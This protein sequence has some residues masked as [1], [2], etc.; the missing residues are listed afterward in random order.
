MR[1]HFIWSVA[2]IFAVSNFRRRRKN[3]GSFPDSRA[4]FFMSAACPSVLPDSRISGFS[5]YHF[6]T[7]T[8]L[9]LMTAKHFSWVGLGWVGTF[10]LSTTLIV[11]DSCKY[12]PAQVPSERELHSSIFYRA[13]LL[14]YLVPGTAV[15]CHQAARKRFPY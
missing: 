12:L 1:V 15:V 8:H 7:R 10:L 11:D 4:R 13:C 2:L 3:R 6:E 5:F 9:R 14:L